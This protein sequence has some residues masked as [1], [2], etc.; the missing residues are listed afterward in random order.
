MGT[1]ERNQLVGATRHTS[2]EQRRV[3]L[4]GTRPIPRILATLDY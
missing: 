1:I 3:G 4:A 2:A